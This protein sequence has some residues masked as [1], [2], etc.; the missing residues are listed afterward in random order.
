MKENVSLSTELQTAREKITF[1]EQKLSENEKLMSKLS[2]EN[3]DLIKRLS[4]TEQFYK[5]CLDLKNDDPQKSQE[6]ARTS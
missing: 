1:L 4:S 6:I 5:Q 3:D 2:S